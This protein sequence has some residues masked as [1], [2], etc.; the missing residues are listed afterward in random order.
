[1]KIRA[2]RHIKYWLAA[3]CMGAFFLCGHV[4]NA[5]KQHVTIYLSITDPDKSGGGLNEL[6]DLPYYRYNENIPV[7]IGVINN[8]KENIFISEDLE[9]IN[10]F[11]HLKLI[12]P[13]G[14]LILPTPKS[15]NTFKIRHQHAVPLGTSKYKGKAISVVPCVLIDPDL[16]IKQEENDLRNIYDLSLP[17]IYSM[18]VQFSAMGSSRGTCALEMFQWQG[19]IKS[20]TEYFFFEGSTEIHILLKEFRNCFSRTLSAEALSPSKRSRQ[21]KTGSDICPIAEITANRSVK[22][23]TIDRTTLRIN[24]IKAKIIGNQI[25]IDPIIVGANTH[26]IKHRLKK[27]EPGKPYRVIISGKLK[28]GEY[29]GGARTICMKNRP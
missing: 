13:A 24:G 25:N 16:S 6:N 10:Y 12:N 5:Q 27:P 26:N 15:D 20:N 7:K 2:E 11:H 3:I 23:E 8:S 1:M 9:T 19:I 29:F 14:V 4:V 18:Q 22:L 28:S 21:P 17:G